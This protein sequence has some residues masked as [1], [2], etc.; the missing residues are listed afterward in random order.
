ML[1]HGNARFW[2]YVEEEALH[3]FLSNASALGKSI[4]RILIRPH[5]S[6]RAEKYSWAQHGFELPIEM[7]GARTL[8]EE[9]ADS[10][11]VVGCESM[12]MVI[13][14]HAGK[15]VVSCIPPEGRTCVLPHAGIISL[16]NILGM[17]KQQLLVNK[18]TSYDKNE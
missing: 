13:A 12:A 9:I 16:Q 10:D 8:L 15:K 4:E 2:G 18:R 5:P 7:G 14:L 3:Y 1:R 6:E 17:K 11:F